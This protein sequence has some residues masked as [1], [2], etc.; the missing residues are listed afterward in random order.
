MELPIYHAQ[1]ND[2]IPGQ[3]TCIIDKYHK[4]TCLLV[5]A[6]VDDNTKSARSNTVSCYQYALIPHETNKSWVIEGLG[7]ENAP[8]HLGIISWL[9]VAQN[10]ALIIQ[11]FVR[12]LLSVLPSQ[13]PQF[14]IAVLLFINPVIIERTFLVDTNVWNTEKTISETW[15]IKPRTKAIFV[16]IIQRRWQLFLLLHAIT[17]VK[18]TQAGEEIS[19][20]IRKTWNVVDNW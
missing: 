7:Q 1:G 17:C 18:M 3:L 4:R 13:T 5:H 12:I 2:H 6:T 16:I 8:L 19:K 11:V 14:L 10:F 15:Q 20:D 9:D